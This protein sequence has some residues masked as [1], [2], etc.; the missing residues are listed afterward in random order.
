MDQVRAH[1][2]KNAH[3]LSLIIETHLLVEGLQKA[4]AADPSQAVLLAALAD[5]AIISL[6]QE[7]QEHHGVSA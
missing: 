1:Q 4:Q 6:A 3:Y 2:A 7:M 5:E